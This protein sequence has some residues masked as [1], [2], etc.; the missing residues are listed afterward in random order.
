MKKTLKLRRQS[1]VASDED[2]EKSMEEKIK[3]LSYSFPGFYCFFLL[4]SRTSN[5][6]E[7]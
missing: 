6:D 2:G 4:F 7:K 5:L 3:T 1:V